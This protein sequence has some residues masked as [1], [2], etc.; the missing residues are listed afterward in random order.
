MKYIILLSIILLGLTNVFSQQTIEK[1]EFDKVMSSSFQALRNIPYRTIEESVMQNS[2]GN[3][4]KT[5]IITEIDGIT[6]R[7]VYES[8]SSASY[9]KTETIFINGKRF[10]KKL[11][12]PWIKEKIE[13]KP[14]QNTLETISNETINKFIGEQVVNEKKIKVYQT[15]QTRKY[16]DKAKGSESTT[17]DTTDYYFDE[18]GLMFKSISTSEMIFK[19]KNEPGSATLMK[20]SKSSRKQIKTVEVDQNIKIEKPKIG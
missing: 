9:M 8:D 19:P 1:A 18:K 3:P 6:R 12:N 13:N 11:D 7:S 15:V 5:K 20:E 4:M 10:V 16:I 2:F 14:F 17:T